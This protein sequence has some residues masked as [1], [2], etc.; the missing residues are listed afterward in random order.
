M[1]TIDES[2]TDQARPP[3]ESLDRLPGPD[4]V[5]AIALIGVVVMNY[6]G[7]LLIRSGGSVPASTAVERFFD[8]WGGPLS[9][10]FAATFVLVAGVGI[11]LLT[12]RCVA[13]RAAGVAGAAAAVTEMRWRL[14]RRGMALYVLGQ[15]LDVIWRGTIIYFYGAMFVIAAVLFTLRSAWIVAVGVASV[16]A[17]WWIE[18]W[19]YWRI[20]DGASVQ[21]L[22]N[23][24]RDTVR[25]FVIDLGV[26]GTHPLLPWL[27]FLC[28]G[29]VLGRSLQTPD[30]GLWCAGTGLILYAAA[31]LVNELADTSFTAQLLSDDSSERGVVYV[32]SALGTALV[33]YALISWVADNARGVG[34]RIIDPLRRAGQMSLSIYI[35]HILVFNLF[36]DWFGW[37][38]PAGLDVAL[39]FSVGFWIAAITGATW[40]HRRFGRG[41]AERVYRAIGG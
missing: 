33:A 37:I 12:R 8:P 22:T 4:V 32:M 14:V 7:Y 1:S 10:R 21:W 35:A 24:G 36:V 40:W 16:L 31:R 18:T 19:T 9:T 20:E 41:P 28:A 26:N 39:W 25:Y 38:D 15:V 3:S 2:L 17:A 27:A 13:E 11:T 30:W 23:P 5:R 29:I 34:V 6:H